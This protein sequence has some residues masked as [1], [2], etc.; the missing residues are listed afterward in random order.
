MRYKLNALF[1]AAFVLGVGM[2]TL[3]PTAAFANESV[4]EK[5]QDAEKKAECMTAEVAAKEKCE[6]ITDAAKSAECT[7]EE[8]AVLEDKF[9]G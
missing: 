2:I 8:A 9:G 4:C 1:A 6:A 7:A 3:M 5:V